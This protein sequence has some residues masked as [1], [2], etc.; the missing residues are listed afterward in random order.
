[1][2]EICERYFT[3]YYRDR[4]FVNF[5]WNFAKICPDASIYSVPA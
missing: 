3:M 1:M 2:A 5:D 4:N